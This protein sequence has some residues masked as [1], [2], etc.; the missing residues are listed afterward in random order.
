MFDNFRHD[1]DREYCKLTHESGSDCYTPRQA[2]TT[3]DRSEVIA[4][5]YKSCHHMSRLRE[6]GQMS[7]VL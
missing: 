4:G 7:R 3:L 5:S 6:L 2:S 1:W